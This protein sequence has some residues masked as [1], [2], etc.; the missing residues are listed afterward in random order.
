MKETPLTR[1]VDAV[2]ALKLK[3]VD[4]WVAGVV[5]ALEDVGTPEKLIG[6]PY[7]QWTPADLQA[8]GRIYGEEPNPLSRLIA[9]KKYQ[10]VD[11]LEAEVRR[12]EKEVV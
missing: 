2:V 1:A 5:E 11:A 6:K 8:L 4:A 9:K 12:L 7:E 3:A 10:E